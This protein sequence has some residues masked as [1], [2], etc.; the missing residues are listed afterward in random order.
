MSADFLNINAAV[1]GDANC[2]EFGPQT[3]SGRIDFEK[4]FRCLCVFDTAKSFAKPQEMNSVLAIFDK[5]TVLDFNQ[6]VAT[7]DPN[8]NT[9]LNLQLVQQEELSG[10]LV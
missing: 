4:D 10:D 6:I 5:N 3:R 2:Y 8:D 7:R 1:S 9:K